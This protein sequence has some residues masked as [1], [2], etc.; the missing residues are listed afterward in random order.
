MCGRFAVTTD[1]ALL[2]ARIDA[3]DEVTPAR[4]WAP[5]YNVAPTTEISAVVTTPDVPGDPPTRRI[6]LMRWGLVPSWSKPG[7]DGGPDPK[8]PLLINARAE[9]VT[10]SPAF[11]DSARHRRCLIPVDG[12]YEW[13]A[14][15]LAGSGPASV[16][17]TPFFL[18]CADGAT[19]FLAGLWSVWQP[20]TRP[21]DGP[22]VT[23]AIITR[24]AV[25]VSAR[26]HHR[27]PLILDESDWGTW[28][29][30]AIP[31]DQGVLSRSPDPT[32]IEAHEVSRLVNSVRN[33][34]PELIAPAAPPPGQLTLL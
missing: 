31:L 1:P 18:H 23:C 2:A 7:P 30:T 20:A 6:R 28:L 29:D 22:L 11:R 26:I 8:A 12:W 19:V 15:P 14:D 5:N 3:V 24:E 32:G 13:S 25:G 10:T 16:G 21:S 9:T 17:K 27:M 34:G 33:N 4:A